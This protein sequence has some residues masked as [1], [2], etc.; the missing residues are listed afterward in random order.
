[1]GASPRLPFAPVA[2]EPFEWP[3]I[4][5]LLSEA[6]EEDFAGRRRWLDKVPDESKA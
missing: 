4:R 6:N 1:M 2:E 3:Q 5:A